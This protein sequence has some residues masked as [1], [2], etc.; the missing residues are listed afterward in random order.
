VVD[1]QTGRC[2]SNEVNVMLDFDLDTPPCLMLSSP[3]DLEPVL[4]VCM[5]ATRGATSGRMQVSQMEIIPVYD[6]I[7]LHGL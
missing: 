4:T 3:S 5:D 6:P 2:V 1:E 7:Y